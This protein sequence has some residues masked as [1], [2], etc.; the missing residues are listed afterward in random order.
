MTGG[1]FRFTISHM[2]DLSRERLITLKEAAALVPSRR[3]R[4]VSP[5]TVYG[6]CRVGHK[7]RKLES[8]RRPSGDWLT[9]AEAVGRFLSGVAEGAERPPPVENDAAYW[10]ARLKGA[11]W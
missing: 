9:S 8:V 7:G 11:G 3:G 10:E 4:T 6:W 1:G 2:I 5:K